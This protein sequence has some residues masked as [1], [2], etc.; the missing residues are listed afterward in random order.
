MDFGLS[1]EQVA[2]KATIKRFLEEQCPT[3]RVR[4]IMESESGHDSGLWKGLVD[5][6]LA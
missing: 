2:L 6:L 5:L 4:A 1:E 3:T